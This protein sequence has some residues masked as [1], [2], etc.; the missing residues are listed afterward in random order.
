MVGTEKM[1][2]GITGKMSFF[3]FKPLLGAQEI[4]DKKIET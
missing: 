1:L 3:S 4:L 2:P